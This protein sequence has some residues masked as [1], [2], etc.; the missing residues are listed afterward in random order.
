MDSVAF[1]DILIE[2][3][4]TKRDEMKCEQKDR[5]RND[6]SNRR[7]SKIRATI[8]LAVIGILLSLI[9]QFA[10]EFSGNPDRSWYMVSCLGLFPLIAIGLVWLGGSNLGKK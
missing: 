2:K 3:E 8:V 6:A 10:G 9:G 1:R 4:K 5:E 7:S